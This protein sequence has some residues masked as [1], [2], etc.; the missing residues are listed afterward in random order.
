M[1]SPRR[2]A[3]LESF[4]KREIGEILLHKLNDPRIGFVS[5]TKVE[6]SRDCS[7]LKVFVSVLGND[8]ERSKIIHALNGGKKYIA[9]EA[10]KHLQ[11]H[12]MPT[13]SFLLDGSIEKGIE[14]CI[15]IDRLTEE[16]NS[17]QDSQDDEQNEDQE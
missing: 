17:R 14:I 16:R 4:L 1:A 2:I 5:I 7:H 15:I 10:F 8:S 12:S 13:M 3:K 9:K 11:L 6:M